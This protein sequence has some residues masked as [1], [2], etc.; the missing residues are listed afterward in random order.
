MAKTNVEGTRSIKG[1]KRGIS[2]IRSVKQPNNCSAV[3]FRRV[4]VLTAFQKAR[5]LNCCFDC[6][7]QTVS[8]LNGFSHMLCL[9][10]ILSI[11]LLPG[12]QDT[13]LILARIT[14]SSYRERQCI[15]PSR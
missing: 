1:E 8:H 15:T 13:I 9:S 3:L 5:P 7:V 10:S 2:I 14:S 11:I 4:T 6:H 12:Y